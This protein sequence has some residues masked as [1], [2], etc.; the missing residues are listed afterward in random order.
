MK[1]GVTGRGRLRPRKTVLLTIRG[2]GRP[3]PFLEPALTLCFHVERLA[4]LA[5]VGMTSVLIDSS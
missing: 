2:R 1:A 4:D 5:R 3:R